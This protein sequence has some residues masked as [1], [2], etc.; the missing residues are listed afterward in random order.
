MTVSEIKNISK[1]VFYGKLTELSIL[2]T[3]FAIII[4]LKKVTELT[5]AYIFLSAEV[6]T[7]NEL[8]VPS[9]FPWLIIQILLD[10]TEFIMLIPLK[11]RIA[12]YLYNTSDM[13]F[14]NASKISE[15]KKTLKI[16]FLWIIIKIICFFSFLPFVF[17]IRASLKFIIKAYEV[18]G[19]E[20]YILLS[21]YCFVFA[22]FFLS[23][24][25]Y[26]FTGTLLSPFILMQNP[27]KNVFTTVIQ[28]FKDMHG[29]RKDFFKFT[30]AFILWGLLSIFIVTIPFVMAKY[31]SWFSI[32]VADILNNRKDSEYI[33]C[34]ISSTNTQEKIL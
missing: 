10:I 25:F 3:I 33:K 28:S 20:G 24:Y 26:T 21:F 1:R 8:F 18:S 32:F 7:V 22:L 6:I 13:N 31:L 2:T 23:R 4:L 16:S 17:S 15:I 29:R 34:E 27:D 9:H 30:S 12:E 11:N 14:I 19:S 5:I